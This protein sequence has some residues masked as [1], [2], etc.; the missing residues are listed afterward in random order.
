MTT[1]T[2][3]LNQI[4]DEH[5]NVDLNKLDLRLMH[6]TESDFGLDN[7]NN[8]VHNGQS[9]TSGDYAFGYDGDN[10]I[11]LEVSLANLGSIATTQYVDDKINALIG[12]T[13]PALNTLGK[14][15]EFMNDD[16]NYVYKTRDLINKQR[17]QVFEGDGIRDQF[18]IA[19]PWLPQDKTCHPPKADKVDVYLNGVKLRSQIVDPNNRNSN[20]TTGYDYRLF[21]ESPEYEYYDLR[22]NPQMFTENRDHGTHLHAQGSTVHEPNVLEYYSD[23]MINNVDPWAQ[24]LSAPGLWMGG[25]FCE[26]QSEDHDHGITWEG[27]IWARGRNT[28]PPTDGIPNSMTYRIMVAEGKQGWYVPT[29]WRLKVHP[30][31]NIGTKESAILR[32]RTKLHYGMFGKKYDENMI[33]WTNPED[34]LKLYKFHYSDWSWFENGDIV[35]GKKFGPTGPG[36]GEIVS[37]D[38]SKDT[39]TAFTHFWNWNGDIDKLTNTRTREFT[40]DIGAYTLNYVAHLQHSVDYHPEINPTASPFRY[41]G[42]MPTMGTRNAS[43]MKLMADTSYMGNR[44]HIM[45]AYVQGDLSTITT[46]NK[47]CPG[48][49]DNTLHITKYQGGFGTDLVLTTEG[50]HS[51]VGWPSVYNTTTYSSLQEHRHH[52]PYTGY[53]PINGIPMGTVYYDDGM[54]DWG[55][56]PGFSYMGAEND[57]NKMSSVDY[58]YAYGGA[59]NGGFT[60]VHRLTPNVDK[61]DYVY[62]IRLSPELSPLAE[63]DK[64]IVRT[65]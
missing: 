61:N 4:L 11:P 52:F 51:Y 6:L 38:S 33:D 59:E 14:L 29:S 3:K 13:D 5:G 28:N 44:P 18:C 39:M 8:L 24:Q 54:M 27:D 56:F 17:L 49:P 9:I 34:V 53:E 10:W 31:M 40:N 62:G 35:N 42:F 65:Y 2:E 22:A 43:N 48:W 57:I 21:G 20:L 32:K 64:L 30:F 23:F 7:Q 12:N 37:L 16:P 55:G 47:D 50:Q 60:R 15:K 45:S 63:G 1:Y 36:T 46:M 25:M 19:A 58:E 26:V 41:E